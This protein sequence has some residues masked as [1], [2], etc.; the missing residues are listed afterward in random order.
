MKKILKNDI[1]GSY[2]IACEC[3]ND[4]ER[5]TLFEKCINS[6]VKK[7]DKV[8]ELGAGT[9]ILS[10][11][12]AA[13]GA[14]NVD[15]VEL[16]KPAA[17]IAKNNIEFNNYSN[18]INVINKNALLIGR[19][20]LTTQPNIVIMEM[21]STGLI[22]EQQVPAFNNLIK[23]N[24]ISKNTVFIPSAYETS[25][26]LVNVDYN[27]HG[28]IL[29]SILHQEKWQRNLIN[30]QHSNVN[31]F[32]YI[33]FNLL[34]KNRK[35]IPLKLEKELIFDVIVPGTINGLMINGSAI[36]DKSTRVEWTSALNIPIIVPFDDIE[37]SHGDRINLK[38]NYIMGKGLEKLSIN[39]DKKV[40]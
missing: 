19:R 12:A 29:K 33:D 1:F 21:I 3:L 9:G 24:L 5:T 31:K 28:F 13:S 14:L 26:I 16:A 17:I 6:T 4:H 38:I 36:L 15:S 37:V 32:H 40:S 11:I 30:S 18:V 39:I 23:K 34:A 10:L 25:A 8:L 27:F 20:D 2:Q 22:E 35:S 7:G